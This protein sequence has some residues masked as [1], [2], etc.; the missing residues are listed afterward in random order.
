MATKGVFYAGEHQSP[1]I[2]ADGYTITKVVGGEKRT[3]DDYK[4]G[5]RNY[6]R[7]FVWVRDLCVGFFHLLAAILILSG[8][9]EFCLE[10]NILKQDIVKADGNYNE[11]YMGWTLWFVGFLFFAGIG[12]RTA[13]PTPAAALQ[14]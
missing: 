2:G 6:W 14:L 4:F 8:A 9:I 13:L 1:G 12:V 5:S 3:I 11:G 10:A 7:G